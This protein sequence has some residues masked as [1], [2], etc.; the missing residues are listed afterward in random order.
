[1]YSSTAVQLKLQ[2][3]SRCSVVAVMSSSALGKMLHADAYIVRARRTLAT[4]A[5]VSGLAAEDR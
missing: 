5:T 1:M 4:L 2:E 3:S